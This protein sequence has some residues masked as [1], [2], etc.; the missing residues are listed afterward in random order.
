[1]LVHILDK[2]E[3]ALNIKKDALDTGVVI[4]RK[5]FEVIYK[6]SPHKQRKNET[7]L[8]QDGVLSVYVHQNELTT[9]NIYKINLDKLYQKIQD[10][11]LK[12]LK[13]GV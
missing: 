7:V 1:M 2:I 3:Y 8:I 10:N 9:Y 6:I 5:D 4:F 11:P 12:K 13:G